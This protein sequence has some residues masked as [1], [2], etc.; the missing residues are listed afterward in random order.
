MAPMIYDL[1]QAL[2]NPQIPWSSSGSAITA[3]FEPWVCGIGHGLYVQYFE[4]D[5]ALPVYDKNRNFARG[6]EG[7]LLIDPHGA[8]LKPGKFQD[9]FL[10]RRRQDADHLHR[11]RKD[12]FGHTY[13]ECLKLALVLD[14]T[15]DRTL[16]RS[17][18]KEVEK[19]LKSK[20]D[21]WLRRRDLLHAMSTRRGDW[22][23][24]RR[25]VPP[26]ELKE[27]M[28]AIVAQTAM[29]VGIKVDR[30]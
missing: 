21:E 12:Q 7:M 22:R 11:T 5:A 9:G 18:T 14:L 13:R 1:T 4:N 19:L 3:H 6:G 20:V 2:L 23:R 8:S 16:T 17:A 15:N 25:L 10:R 24:L 26:D 27:P 28:L 29:E 30:T